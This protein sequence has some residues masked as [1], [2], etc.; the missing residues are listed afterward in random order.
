MNTSSGTTRLAWSR[1]ALIVATII[2]IAAVGMATLGRKTPDHPPTTSAASQQAPD[3][4]EMIAKLKERLKQDPSSSEGWRL[5]GWSLSETGQYAEA[6]DAYRR[7]TTLN[8]QRAELW[9]A[10]GEVLVLGGGSGLSQEAQDAF[11]KA[12]AADPKDARARFFVGAV[13]EEQGDPKGAIADW[14]ALL[15]DSPPDAPWTRPVRKKIEETAAAGK[16]DVTA[17]LA[18]LPAPDPTS[19]QG[20]AIAELPP[21]QQREMIGKMVESLAA[22]LRTNP[23]DP[24]GWVQ[25]MRSRMVL[26]DKAGA[27]QAFKGA[28]SAYTDDQAQQAA[29]KQAAQTLGVPG[30]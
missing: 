4:G 22:K 8:P 10:L 19:E 6:A 1:P 21:A 13:K 7:A 25:L 29:F 20:R 3:M 9:S 16:I 5:L 18:A 11:R 28:S 26:G 17:E 23:R 15:K 12:L 2:A 24:E 14:I 30:A 27:A